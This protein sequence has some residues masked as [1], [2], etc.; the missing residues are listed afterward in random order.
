MTTK[1]L[2][3]AAYGDVRAGIID[4][5]EGA[6]RAAARS[7]NALMTASYWEIGRRGTPLTVVRN[8]VR[9]AGWRIDA[10]SRPAENAYHRFF[11]LG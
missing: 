11:T 1:P 10:E 2:S 3:P 8:A 4:L 6:R 9:A 7:V 5:V